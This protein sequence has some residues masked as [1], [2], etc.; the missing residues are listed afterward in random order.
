M[1]IFGMEIA[2][3][4]VSCPKCNNVYKYYDFLSHGEICHND[5]NESVENNYGDEYRLEYDYETD[6]ENEIED[7]MEYIE[8]SKYKNISSSLL[9]SSIHMNINMNNYNYGINSLD[10]S[11]IENIISHRDTENNINM[12][13]N[14]I[15]DLITDFHNVDIGLG[16]ENLFLYG[17]K[18]KTLHTTNCVICFGTFPAGN[19]FYIMKCLHSFCNDCTEKWFDLKSTCPL[20]NRNLKMKM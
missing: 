10:R 2:D 9:E 4:L 16:K 8:L 7:E 12:I 11:L 1:D 19:D 17:N 15:N 13:D 6:D 18:H 14:S 20:C 3:N 5:D